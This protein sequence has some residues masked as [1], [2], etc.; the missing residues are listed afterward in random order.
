MYLE[1]YQEFVSQIANIS[2]PVVQQRFINLSSSD[3]N[4]YLPQY[5]PTL[6]QFEQE[7]DQHS[8]T[9]EKLKKVPAFDGKKEYNNT[10]N[11][12][13]RLLSIMRSFLLS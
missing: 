13:R 9:D 11:L 10:D 8:K 3:V 4:Q 12:H 1:D 5:I 6:H 2:F 7:F